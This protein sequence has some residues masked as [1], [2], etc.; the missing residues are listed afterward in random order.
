MARP[1][2][3]CAALLLAC[4][5]SAGA[6]NWIALPDDRMPEAQAA[7]EHAV[8]YMNFR[9]IFCGSGALNALLSASHLPEDGSGDVRLFLTM[10]VDIAGENVV[11]MA[12]VYKS[13]GASQWQVRKA[14]AQTS[15]VRS[16]CARNAT[17]ALPVLCEPRGVLTPYSQVLLPGAIKNRKSSF[18]EHYTSLQDKW[19]R[20]PETDAFVVEGSG[21]ID[22]M[23]KNSQII[24]PID[25]VQPEIK[26]I[27]HSEVR[28]RDIGVEMSG[29]H[30]S[31]AGVPMTDV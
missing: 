8:K 29:E 20:V 9:S 25:N 5:Q 17:H 2:A 21:K 6:V 1:A 4:A 22:M 14:P 28:G 7:A 11:T 26:Q 19:R 18:P 16:R 31:P 23:L 3:L 12:E 13:P 30:S 10:D 24:M 15:G 27:L